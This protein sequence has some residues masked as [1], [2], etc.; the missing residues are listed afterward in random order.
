MQG[1]HIV[2]AVFAALVVAAAAM[3]VY[4]LVKKDKKENMDVADMKRP[5]LPEYAMCPEQDLVCDHKVSGPGFH[6][7]PKLSYRNVH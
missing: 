2:M 6:T 7:T 5:Y 3:G 4:E 1:K